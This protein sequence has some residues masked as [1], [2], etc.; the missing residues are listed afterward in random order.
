MKT[1]NVRVQ[2]RDDWRLVA[3]DAPVDVS[4]AVLLSL[5]RWNREV[6]AGEIDLRRVGL[7]LETDDNVEALSGP[8]P[9]VR[10][11]DLHFADFTD[12]RH[13]SN[14][15]L[16]RQRFGYQGELRASGDVTRDQVLYLA[17][18]GFNAFE[19]ADDSQLEEALASLDDFSEYYQAS[20]DQALPLYRRR[21]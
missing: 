16:L 15:R 18:C 21:G 8:F 4:R 1:R 5:E 12:G 11:I 7:R 9:N 2:T 20:A 6:D 3:D 13:Y 10:I 14:A 19:M 17:R